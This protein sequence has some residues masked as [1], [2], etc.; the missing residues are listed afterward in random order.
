M[1]NIIHGIYGQHLTLKNSKGEQRKRVWAGF[2]PK[3]KDF[4]FAQHLFNGANTFR[5]L[6]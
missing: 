4:N 5:Q 6:S 3:L 2:F 1:Y